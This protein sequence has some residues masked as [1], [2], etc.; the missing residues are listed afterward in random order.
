M[1]VDHPFPADPPMTSTVWAVILHYDT[2][3]MLLD[4]VASF[5]PVTHPDFRILVVDNGS[6]DEAAGAVQARFPDVHV[7]R[8]DAN[9]GYCGGNNAG[10]EYALA[11]GADHI[12]VVNADTVVINPDFVTELVEVME[13]RPDAGI[14]G[15]LVYLRRRGDVQN[16]AARLPTFRR[17]AGSWIRS[18]LRPPREVAPREIREVEVLN[19]VCILLR[20]AFLDDV[21]VYDRHIFMYGDDWD[22]T[23]RARRR[24]WR[25][26]QAPVES[27][28]HLQSPEGYDPLSMVSFLLKRNAV[29]VMAKHGHRL[30]ALAIALGGLGV[31]LGRAL[32]ATLRGAEARRSWA[33]ARCLAR[34]Y[35][36]ALRQRVDVP[37]FGPPVRPW[38]SMIGASDV[39]ASSDAAS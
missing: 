11:R 16:T 31:T 13:S 25:S 36:A 26:Y 20:R 6:S 14:V 12:L 4:C 28:V 34:S 18:R 7:R 9:T 10:I 27:V 2:G 35:G 5:M 15:P 38:S 24:G 1:G 22:L 37:E 19:G 30:G 29:Y 23:L 39:Q 32:R 17:K 21:G 33:F 3:P 8:L